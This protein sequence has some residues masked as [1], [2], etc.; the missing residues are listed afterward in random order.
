MWINK[1]IYDILENMKRFLIEQ[2]RQYEHKVK[3][4]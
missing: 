3:W 1:S 4:A 2:W